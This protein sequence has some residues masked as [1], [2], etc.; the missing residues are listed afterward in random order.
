MQGGCRWTHDHLSDS[1][2][3]P[4]H[5]V[6]SHVPIFTWVLQML[7]INCENGCFNDCFYL[8]FWGPINQVPKSAREYVLGNLLVRL[9]LCMSLETQPASIPVYISFEQMQ[10]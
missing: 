5:D 1:S 2:H 6:D 3:R 7:I 9:A 8:F 4:A 10:M